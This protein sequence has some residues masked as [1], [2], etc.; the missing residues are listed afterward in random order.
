MQMIKKNTLRAA[1]M[2]LLVLCFAAAAKH[3][4]LA[5]ADL[6]YAVAEAFRYETVVFACATYDGGLFP[7]MENLLYRLSSKNFQNKKIALVE[8]GSWGPMA[9]GKMKAEL[10]KLSGMEFVG[11]T[12]TIKGAVQESDKEKLKELAKDIRG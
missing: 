5:G 11:Q 1:L 7:C 6:S 9:A 4:T 2:L 10:E 12:V 8:N 3:L